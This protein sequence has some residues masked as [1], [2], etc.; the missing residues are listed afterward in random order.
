MLKNIIS[1]IFTN[2]VHNYLTMC[3]EIADVGLNYWCC[4]AAIL[5]AIGL[6]AGMWALG[7]LEYYLLSIRL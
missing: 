6:C 7:H 5:G 2:H 1:K 3:K 4:V